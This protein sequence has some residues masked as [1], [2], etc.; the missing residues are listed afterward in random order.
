MFL[1]TIPCFDYQKL[2]TECGSPSFELQS[3]D[4]GIGGHTDWFRD[5]ENILG[6]DLKP[7]QFGIVQFDFIVDPTWFAATS[8][9]LP[10]LRASSDLFSVQ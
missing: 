7:K 8:L 4:W 6:T 10:N 3:E 2:R 1:D 5:Y 9:D